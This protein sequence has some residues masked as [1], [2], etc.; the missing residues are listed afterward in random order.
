MFFFGLN[1]IIFA[2]FSPIPWFDEE[3]VFYQE[4]QREEE[5]SLQKQSQDVFSHHIELQWGGYVL[6]ICTN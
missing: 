3:V 5:G 6:Q 1:T 2:L 4:I